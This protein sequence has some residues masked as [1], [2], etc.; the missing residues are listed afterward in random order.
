MAKFPNDKHVKNLKMKCQHCHARE[1]T[2]NYVG[3]G[4]VLAFTHGMYQRWCRI[5]VLEVQLEYAEK[6]AK[7]I[8]KLKK[9]LQ[10]GVRID[11]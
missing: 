1:A 6:I 3:E 9:E 7:N 8:P 4:G 10:K 2:D 11:E 5:C